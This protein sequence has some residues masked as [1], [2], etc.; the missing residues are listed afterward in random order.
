MQTAV[1]TPKRTTKS[2]ARGFK[3]GDQVTVEGQVLRVLDGPG[4]P[5]LIMLDATGTKMVIHAH[6]LPNGAKLKGSDSVRVPGVITRVGESPTPEYTP[7]SIAI[8]GYTASKVTMAAQYVR[9]A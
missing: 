5:R 7:I 8:D 9:A 4:D 1:E 6:W 3:V 2:K